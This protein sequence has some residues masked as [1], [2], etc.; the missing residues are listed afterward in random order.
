MSRD[1]NELI[2]AYLDEELSAAEQQQLAEWIKADASHARQFARAAMLHD[3]LQGEIAAA[4]DL[5][6]AA[7]DEPAG[8][9][10]VVAFPGLAATRWLLPL[11]AAIALMLTLPYWRSSTEPPAAQAPAPVKLTGFVTL[12]Y[13]VDAEFASGAKPSTG[14][15][16]DAGTI[17]LQ[18]GMLRLE[19]DSG[20][21][22]ILQGPAEYEILSADRT[23]LRAGKLTATV[24]H[25]AEGFRVET[26]N[27]EVTD[28]GTAFG[29]ELDEQ[30]A[31][32]VTVFEGK[33]EVAEPGSP[34]S[35]LL[36]EGEALRIE[37]GKGLQAVAFDEK[38]F[39]RL[40]PVAS[41]IESSTGAFRLLPPWRRLRFVSSDEFIF[42]RPERHRVRLI[43]PLR[44]NISE[45]GR[46]VTE[47][48]L[49]PADLP[50]GRWIRSVLIHQQPEEPRVSNVR[51]MT[52]SITFD[53]PILGLI[54]LHEELMASAGRFSPMPAGEQ[55][56]RREVDLNGKA[57]GDVVTL[58]PDRR[59]LTVE[60]AS[61]LNSSDLIRVIV[62][63]GQPDLALR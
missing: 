31:S 20:V 10:K 38:P 36:R 56:P 42:M 17:A 13:A 27:A 16:L 48:Q 30:G 46:Y 6:T 32:R 62:D 4:V 57:V 55:D 52:G 50:E 25:G 22:V 14:Q 59:T 7:D 34:G 53:R 24:P 18:S 11:A 21:E 44:V 39:E 51:R 33:V 5:E 47:D 2:S 54:I 49:T 1:V 23:K 8:E 19:F 3:R 58:S 43:E 63:A 61:P 9:D 60:L 45:P 29:V 35:R 26:P 12:A 37:Q 41:G 28:L 15:R 40:F